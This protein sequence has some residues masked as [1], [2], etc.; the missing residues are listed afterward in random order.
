MASNDVSTTRRNRFWLYAPF[1]LLILIAI[2]WSAGWFVVRDRAVAA[3]DRFLAVEA[4]AGRQWT[5]VDRSVSGYPFRIE[6][7]CKTVAVRRGPVTASA[8]RLLAVAQVYK[9]RHVITSLEGPFRLS[10]DTVSVTGAWDLLETSFHGV[11]GGFQRAS[12]VTERP[13]IEI[14]GV[15]PDLLRL[16]SEHLEAHLR[17]NP[18]RPA[19]KAYDVALSTLGTRLPLLDQLVGG[20]EAAD[21]AVDLTATVAE[22]FRGRPIAQELERWR[23]ANGKLEILMLSLSKGTSR[24][25]AKGDLQLDELHRLEGELNVAAAGLTGLISRL[26]GNRSSGA[27]LGAILGQAPEPGAGTAN[28][29]TPLPPLRLENGRVL[30]GP[31]AIPNLRLPPLY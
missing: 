18:R 22:G 16:E 28:G 29:L 7:S 14:A 10:D 12:L 1:T 26:T 6:V 27:L 3:I 25:Q 9:P 31:F 4:A 5:C 8:S 11:Q 19:E 20:S 30:L 15:A 17:P 2:A 13:R 24:L 21:L 23:Q